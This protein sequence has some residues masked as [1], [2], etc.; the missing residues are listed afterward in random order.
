MT[1]TPH[2]A[3]RLIKVRCYVVV[4]KAHAT[5]GALHPP[6]TT[7]SEEGCSG[8]VHQTLAPGLV[9]RL[10]QF[11]AT[12]AILDIATTLRARVA[13]CLVMSDPAAKGK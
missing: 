10:E 1:K 8:I 6:W 4:S 3:L 2:W 7:P 13:V 12:L 11:F 5:L 9:S